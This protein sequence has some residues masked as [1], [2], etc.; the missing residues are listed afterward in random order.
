MEQGII[1]LE[2]DYDSIFLPVYKPLRETDAVIKFLYG[3]RDSGKS[4][5]IAQRKILQCLQNDYFRCVLI[6]KTKSSIKDSQWQMIKDVCEEWGIDHFFDFNSSPLEIK[7]INGNKFICRGMDDPGNIKSIS[8]PSDAWVEE[9]NQLTQEDWIYLMT[10]LR[11]NSNEPVNIDFSFNPECDG[12]YQEFWLYNDYFSHTTE[13]SFSHTL[14]YSVGIETVYVKYIAVHST[15]HDNR[16]VTAER[17]ANLESLATIN[18]YWYRVFT[19]GEWG[20]QLNES[21]WAFA[22]DKGKHVGVIQPTLNRS[23][24]LYI[25]CD[26]NRNPM[27]WGIIQWAGT[28]NDPINVLKAYKIPNMG[29]DG[30]CDVILR[31]YPGCLYIVTGDYSG[32]TDTTLFQD[33]MNNYTIIQKKLM[34]ARPQIRIAPN[35]PLKKNR[36]LVNLTFTHMQI[37]IH[38]IEAKPLI[39]DC[40]NVKALADGTIEKTDRKNPAQQADSI[41]WFR[42]FCNMFVRDTIQRIVGNHFEM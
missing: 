42:Y 34:L 15:Y 28:V 35:P 17:K 10:T 9:G 37:N 12:D 6:K 21:P 22:F 13:K 20:N 11:N 39:Y 1:D 18:Y 16:Y 40:E 24:P 32:N 19:L 33:S 25:S 3:G 41:D 4:R 26:F 36:T 8:N 27:C 14:T 29:T 23:L 38:S 5:D 31:D 2:I 7:C 30:L